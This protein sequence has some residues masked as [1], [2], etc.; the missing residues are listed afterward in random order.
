MIAGDFHLIAPLSE[1]SFQYS[2]QS[3]GVSLSDWHVCVCDASQLLCSILG[4]GDMK[5][6]EFLLGTHNTAEQ[7]N[8]SDQT[9]NLPPLTQIK[10]H[11]RSS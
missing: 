4:T 3:P 11:F 6:L 9:P 8:R 7:I 10:A 1:I 2:G 5:V